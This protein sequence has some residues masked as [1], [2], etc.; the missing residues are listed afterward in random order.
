[1][2]GG[3]DAPVAERCGLVRNAL[4][5]LEPVSLVFNGRLVLFSALPSTAQRVRIDGASGSLHIQPAR[6]APGY[7]GRF[8]IVD[9]DPTEA[10]V[11]VRIFGRGGR[12]ITP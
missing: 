4:R 12:A 8:F 11:T 5:H 3:L 1:M 2:A 10:P 6:Q 7:P 9:L